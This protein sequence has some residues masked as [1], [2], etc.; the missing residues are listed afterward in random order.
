MM[1][2]LFA[3]KN[4][5]TIQYWNICP[6]EDLLDRLA[7]DKKC[8]GQKIVHLLSNSFFPVDLSEGT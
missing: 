8:M 1:D 7:K 2:L 6:L 3:V 5:K 4:I